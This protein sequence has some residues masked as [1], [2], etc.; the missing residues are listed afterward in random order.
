MNTRV[1][2]VRIVECGVDVSKF[3]YVPDGVVLIRLIVAVSLRRRRQPVY[4]IVSEA[5]SYR[6][7]RVY[8]TLYTSD[9][10]VGVIQIL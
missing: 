6:C 7:D 4:V 1:L 2:R 3:G 9:V 10:V 8:D 5:L